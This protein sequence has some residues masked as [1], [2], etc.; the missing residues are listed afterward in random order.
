MQTTD[1]KPSPIISIRGFTFLEV[2]AVLALFGIITL[3]VLARQQTSNTSLPAR[4]QVLKAHL[5]YAQSR[6][7]NNDETWWIQ[8]DRTH[9]TYALFFKT[10]TTDTSAGLPGEDTRKVD[11]TSYGISGLDCVPECTDSFIM[12]FDTW[13][14]PCSDTNGSIPYANDTTLT[15]R[16]TD[17]DSSSITITRNTGFIP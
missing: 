2:I 16:D 9:M 17:G 14:R 10:G 11:L 8:F 5:R 13:G 12:A 7:M 15:L 3:V 6:A 4:T 1:V